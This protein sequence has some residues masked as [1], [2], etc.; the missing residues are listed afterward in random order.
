MAFKISSDTIIN[1]NV[2][3]GSDLTLVNENGISY[4]TNPGALT[5]SASGHALYLGY[6]SSLIDITAPNV[7]YS[8]GISNVLDFYNPGR[9]QSAYKFVMKIPGNSG[10]SGFGRSVST[11]GFSYIPNFHSGGSREALAFD[12]SPD[13]LH[14]YIINDD[15]ERVSYYTNTV[16]WG[17]STI[18]FNHNMSTSSQF[19][20]GTSNIRQIRI[21]EDGY[22]FYILAYDN[23]SA[24]DKMHQYTL[25]T[26][27]DLSTASHHSSATFSVDF[28]GPVTEDFYWFEFKRDGK[29]IL[30]RSS[31]Y[32]AVL[33]LSI[34]WN[35]NSS[36][37]TI[38]SY[39]AGN[40][41]FKSK[42]RLDPDYKKVRSFEYSGISNAGATYTYEWTT[43]WHIGSSL[44]GTFVYKKRQS[45][46]L[47]NNLLSH[48]DF[49]VRPGGHHVAFLF[50]YVLGD[51]L[52]KLNFQDSA[53]HVVPE[54]Y[55]F[56]PHVHFENGAAP[57]FPLDN[58][59]SYVEFISIDSGDNWYA[60][61]LYKG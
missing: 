37:I 45:S 57:D 17:V 31:S 38:D 14:W 29:Q 25:S 39:A 47:T 7:T 56:P 4:I 15:E 18:V 44:S 26:A 16:P 52:Y 46:L 24:L 34:P 50:R 11:A 9:K 6:G 43:P 32:T 23:A 22:W 2:Q 10:V 20:T 54:S 53:G 28:P 61:E 3:L 5:S 41:P 55:T 60:K 30:V 40:A 49:K 59:T 51:R 12:I 19:S 35:F 42:S 58:E 27:F 33:S 1:D 8:S 13:G 21:S 48:T 36:T